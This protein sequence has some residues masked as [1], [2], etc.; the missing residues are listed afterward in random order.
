VAR[1]A[2]AVPP[3]YRGFRWIPACFRLIAAKVAPPF[4]ISESLIHSA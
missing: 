3:L 2:L 1:S 4:Q